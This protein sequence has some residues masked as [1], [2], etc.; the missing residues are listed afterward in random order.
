MRNICGTVLVRSWER[1]WALGSLPGL[2]LGPGTCYARTQK[3]YA[4]LG[5]WNPGFEREFLT[6]SENSTRVTCDYRESKNYKRRR[7][8]CVCRRRLRLKISLRT[9]A[10]IARVKITNDVNE[11]RDRKRPLRPEAGEISGAKDT[12]RCRIGTKTYAWEVRFCC[13]ACYDCFRGKKQ[14]W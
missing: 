7:Q 13:F 12:V 4:R 11:E 5:T 14:Q 9:P 3:F 1:C 10:I 2:A 6:S 8:I